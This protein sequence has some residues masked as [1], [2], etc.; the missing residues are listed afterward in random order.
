MS[1]A[2]DNSQLLNGAPAPI[3]ASSVNGAARTALVEKANLLADVRAT[4][5]FVEKN[6]LLAEIQGIDGVGSGIDADLLRGL[7]ADFTNS[8]ATNGYQKLPS[9]LII[10]WGV[11]PMGPNSS[12]TTTFPIAFP[13]G[14]LSISICPANGSSSVAQAQDYV[15]GETQ[16]SFIIYHNGNSYT[17]IYWT[18]I[19]Y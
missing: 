14:V 10:Q 1:K 6:N 11:R 15:T 4:G 17:D 18:A 5:A 8:I 2:F 7:P 13:T 19:G 16:T 3:D 9:G 12:F